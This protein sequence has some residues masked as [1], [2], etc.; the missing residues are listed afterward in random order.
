MVCRLFCCRLPRQ[1][2][3]A[4]VQGRVEGRRREE[5]ERV[6]AQVVLFFGVW[7][8]GVRGLWVEEVVSLRE[9]QQ[10]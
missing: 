7:V 2:V 10:R 4:V 5:I 1:G 3:A 6:S 8:L 9:Q